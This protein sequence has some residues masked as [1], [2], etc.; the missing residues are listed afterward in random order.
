MVEPHNNI[1]S[2]QDM[3]AYV[4]KP[5]C[6]HVAPPQGR[7]N[8]DAPVSVALVMEYKPPCL[9]LSGGRPTRRGITSNGLAL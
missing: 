3:R 2:H 9:A 8:K 7:K 5:G 6:F 4:T 1:V